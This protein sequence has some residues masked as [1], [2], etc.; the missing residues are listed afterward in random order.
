M[1]FSP[2]SYT[3]MTMGRRHEFEMREQRV[4]EPEAF[5]QIVGQLLAQ[6]VGRFTVVI[7]GRVGRVGRDVS[8]KF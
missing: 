7:V 2:E 8:K 5:V 6:L 3:V 4:R 1:G